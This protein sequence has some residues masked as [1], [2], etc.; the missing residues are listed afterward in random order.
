M[1]NTSRIYR[2]SNA[3]LHALFI[4]ACIIFAQQAEAQVQCGADRWNLYKDLLK[5][6]K[7]ALVVNQTA[8]VGD[9][10][11]VDYLIKQGVEVVKI[12][13]PEH[14]FR[15]D[16]DAGQEFKDWVDSLTGVP[17]ISLYGQ[18]KKPTGEDLAGVDI[19][20]FDIQDVGARF[21]TYISTLHYIMESCAE[22]DKPLLILDRPNPNGNYIDGPVL[23]AGFESF[24][25]MHRVPIVHGMTIGEYA[26]MINGENWLKDGKQCNLQVIKC[27]NYDHNTFYAPKIKPSP[28][29][30]NITA[31][32]LYP[33]ICLF[34][35]TNVS[36]GRGTE[37][38]FQVI[39][40]PGYERGEFTFTPMPT[41][42]AKNPPFKGLQC[43]GYDLSRSNVEELFNRRHLDLEYLIL[44][45]KNTTKGRYF[46]E[47]GFFDKLAGDKQLRMDIEAGKTS[48]Q[49]SD[50]WQPG[51]KQFQLTRKK[52]LLYKDFH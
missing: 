51:L 39:G 42:G 41:A 25:G 30:P 14:G 28:N 34:E 43:K 33:S 46:L 4:C 29:L 45:Y 8:Q 17:V 21:Y 52:Y 6:E 16:Q 44:F 37:W 32:L 13:A 20:I 1:K 15:G 48:R 47:N 18:R 12:F 23:E 27:K 19:L 7:V 36:L 10:S 26:R 9:S 2:F 35:G 38:P 5:G 50:S 40:M 31:I 24:V 22:S 49:I 11:L 3:V